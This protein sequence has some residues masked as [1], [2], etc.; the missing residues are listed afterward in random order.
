MIE[1]TVLDYLNEQ[2]KP[3]KVYLSEPANTKP[4]GETFVVIQKTGS[5]CENHIF[6]A[7]FAI[8]SY[9]PTLYESAVLNESV[10]EAMFN[11]ISL[12]EITKS[13]LN[14]DYVFIKE[15]TKQNRYQAVF[16]LIHY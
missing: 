1:T 10:K 16:D 6:S 11:I 13:T 15:S 2:L 4:N 7:T 3:V 8:L 5:G 12:D 9:A 14:S